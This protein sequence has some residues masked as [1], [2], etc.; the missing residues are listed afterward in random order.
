MNKILNRLLK[1]KIDAAINHIQSKISWGL[2]DNSPK[3]LTLDE[4]RMWTRSRYETQTQIFQLLEDLKWK[5]NDR[6]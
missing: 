4:L 2:P 6:N 3:G 1:K 5:K